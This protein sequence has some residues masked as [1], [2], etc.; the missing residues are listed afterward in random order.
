MARIRRQIFVSD[1]LVQRVALRVLVRCFRGLEL[2]V[3]GRDGG[4]ELVE[5]DRAV[6]GALNGGAASTSANENESQNS[7]EN[8]GGLNKSVVGPM[9]KR[10]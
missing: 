5:R 3:P 6:D 2:L 4:R 10:A 8:S 1:F 9:L 7:G